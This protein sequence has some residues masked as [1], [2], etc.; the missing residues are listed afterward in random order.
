MRG[1][2]AS[3][4]ALAAAAG[5]ALAPALAAEPPP[6]PGPPQ[7]LTPQRLAPM[8]AAPAS[9]VEPAA[10]TEPAKVGGIEI[11][12]LAPV[13]PAWSGT[14]AP[15]QGGFPARMW[16]GTPRAFVAALLPRLPVTASP[17]LADLTRRLLLSNAAPPAGPDEPGRP[18]LASLRLARLAAAGRSDDFEAVAKML[19]RAGGEEIDRLRIEQRLLAGDK[20]AACGQVTAGVRRYCGAWWE[21]ALIAC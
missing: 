7:R 6:R 17:A 19:P 4:L 21:R 20:E 12:P 3:V 11:A 13:D 9:A 18:D 15:E 2:R 10:A 16:D 8:P 1:S 5:F 14:L